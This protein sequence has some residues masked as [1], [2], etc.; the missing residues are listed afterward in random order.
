MPLWWE[1]S[2]GNGGPEPTEVEAELARVAAFRVRR[3]RP[4]R[5]YEL[6]GVE[7]W[8]FRFNGVPPTGR[9]G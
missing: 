3:P 9:R 2:Y 5:L 1:M 8:T 4:V 7:N 6:H